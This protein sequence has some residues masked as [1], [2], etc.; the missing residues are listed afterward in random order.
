LPFLILL[1]SYNRVNRAR[2]HHP[3]ANRLWLPE[4]ATALISRVVTKRLTMLLDILTEH[5]KCLALPRDIQEAAARNWPSSYF[6]DSAS[7]DENALSLF[8]ICDAR[9]GFS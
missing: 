7:R 1:A 2:A 4:K 9:A 8:E 6:D 5:K 3:A